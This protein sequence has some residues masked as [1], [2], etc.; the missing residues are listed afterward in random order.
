M[1]CRFCKEDMKL[2]Y[3]DDHGAGERVKALAYNLY[4]CPDCLCTMRQDVWDFKGKVWIHN[5]EVFKENE[6]S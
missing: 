4:A 5:G 3:V 2:V 6:Q 1:E